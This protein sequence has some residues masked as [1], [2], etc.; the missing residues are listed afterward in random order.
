MPYHESSWDL[1][2]IKPNDLKKTLKQIENK[3]KKLEKIRPKLNN[4][5]SSKEFM[6]IVN[7]FK[8]LKVLTNKL[9][10]YTYLKFAE[11][12]ANQKAVAQMSMIE[13]FLTKVY[14]NL[15][16]WSLWF[17]HLP[18][19]KAKRLIKKSG[20]YKYHLESTRRTKPYTLK[21]KEEQIINIKDTTGVSALNSIYNI[22]TS[23]FEYKLYNKKYTQEELTTKVK[24]PNPK[25]RKDAYLTLLTKYKS[26]K[27]V[28]GEIYKN[29]IND[30]REESV[31]LRGYKNPL[32]V[33]STNQDIP[34]KA[35]EALLKVSERNQKLFHRFYE[36][37]RKKLKLKKMRRFDLYAP[38]KAK[39][40]KK[41]PYD[42][43]MK[44]VLECYESFHPK[45]KENALKIINAKHIHSK[46]QKNKQSGAFCCGIT[47]TIPP[48][49]L[50]NYTGTLRDVS[51]IAHELG[52]GVHHILASCQTEFTNDAV[53]PLAETAS[54]FGEML[55]SE[56]IMEKDPQKAKELIFYKLDDL[57]ASIIRQAGFVAF[58]IKAHQMMKEGKTIDEMS[59]VYLQDLR[60]QLGPKVE[61]DEI[62][63][64]EWS[65]IP[66]IFHTPFYC[67][68]YA[69]GN[70]LVLALWE[71]YKEKGK[72]FAEKIIKM[73]A[74]GS[75]K[76][77]VD[78]TKAVGV[79]ITSE[80]FW[81]KGFDVI[82]EM[83]KKVE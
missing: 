45:F 19:K 63:A 3:G 31:N 73:L 34:D 21:E 60:K 7:E 14:N 44:M 80:K 32:S 11:N 81:Q 53:L 57:Y 74:A 47:T 59:A 4:N 40:E 68:A 37:K 79:D 83:I 41:V 76:S 17:K 75:S 25:V 78:I 71:M 29:I 9:G 5:I 43:A 35:I 82:E 42:K 69:F 56:K 49:V 15:I 58:E 50:L 2:A 13:N 33:R 54:I 26:N 67:Y 10:C 24:S 27:D 64:Y 77:P 39:K 1:S 22:F 46:I 6:K 62:F 36:I 8:S 30:W 12:S 61:V 18:E 55:L 20:K 16:F 48:F 65:Y 23:Q 72:P 38:I 66:H 52:H 28:L 51:T 70:L